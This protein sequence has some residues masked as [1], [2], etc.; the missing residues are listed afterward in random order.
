MSFEQ[1]FHIIL[2]IQQATKIETRSEVQQL[3]QALEDLKR[4]DD[5]LRF[6]YEYDEADG[7][8]IY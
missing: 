6:A 7:N 5:G 1:V 2:S 8:E 4:K 3:I